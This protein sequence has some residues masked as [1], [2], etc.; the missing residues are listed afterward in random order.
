[1]ISGSF[2][3]SPVSDINP[4][5]TPTRAVEN[6]AST[7]SKHATGGICFGDPLVVPKMQR[8]LT[9]HESNVPKPVEVIAKNNPS[10]N[11]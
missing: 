8:K 11:C 7:T 9:V 2:T 5:L 6:P 1:V 4:P 10:Q 3:P